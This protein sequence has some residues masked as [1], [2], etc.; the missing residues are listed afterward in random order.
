MYG[1]NSYSHTGKNFEIFYVVDV[2]CSIY[3]YLVLRR[4]VLMKGQCIFRN[5]LF[6]FVCQE[7]VKYPFY[8]KVSV[9]CIDPKM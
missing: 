4:S 8:I 9:N 5:I 1:P 7:N 6:T 3:L 2:T